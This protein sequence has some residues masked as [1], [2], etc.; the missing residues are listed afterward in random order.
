MDIQLGIHYILDISEANS[1]L[2]N[3]KKFIVKSLKEAIR[4]SNATL[5]DKITYEFTPQGITA[6][7]LLS[8]SHISIHTWPE[9][10]YAAIDIFTCG[11]HCNPKLACDFLIS[12]FQAGV[13]NLTLIQRGIPIDKSKI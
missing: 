13:F 4:E 8:E 1:D 6:V 3:S 10:G 5:L 11:E 7:C 9:R 12:A 2:L